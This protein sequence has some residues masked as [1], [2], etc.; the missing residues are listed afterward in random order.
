MVDSK[1][2]V[3][4]GGQRSHDGLAGF[5]EAARNLATEPTKI[6]EQMILRIVRALHPL[7]GHAEGLL[8]QARVVDPDESGAVLRRYLD[9]VKI[10][11][12]YFD[13]KPGDPVPRFIAEA[14]HHPVFELT[15]HS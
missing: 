6:V 5:D 15:E 10:T 1:G 12:P 2:L 4:V 9:E 13:A 7:H 14:D 3:I 11:A 8:L